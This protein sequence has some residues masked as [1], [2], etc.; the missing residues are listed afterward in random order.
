MK[1]NK[2]INTE[3]IDKD[4]EELEESLSQLDM[5]A[6]AEQK[7]L[8]P[9]PIGKKEK[10]ELFP[11]AAENPELMDVMGAAL[12]QVNPSTINVESFFAFLKKSNNSELYKDLNIDKATAEKIRG[13]L[14]AYK[15]GTYAAVPLICK[16]WNECPIK[17]SCFFI[18]FVDNKPSPETS[19]FPLLRPCPVEYSVMSLKIQQYIGEYFNKDESSLSPSLITLVTKLAE[20]DIYEIRCDMMLAAGDGTESN[21]GRNFL[22]KYIEV[23]DSSDNPYYGYREHPVLK[24]KERLQSS[25]EKILKQL[26]ATPEA[27]AN[28]KEKEKVTTTTDLASALTKLGNV[29]SKNMEQNKNVSF[30][31]PVD[32]TYVKTIDEDKE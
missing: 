30:G 16:G 5:H 6:L 26:L 23:I 22:Q 15:H 25:R 27:K 29:L 20:L 17:H 3:S 13:H 4:M 1:D 32:Y 10:K 8:L 2:S 11:V 21:S 18:K 28:S 7:E 31:K 19:T 24:I 14:I 9:A 12:E